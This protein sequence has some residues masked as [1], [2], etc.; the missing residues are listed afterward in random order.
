MRLTPLARLPLPLRSGLVALAALPLVACGKDDN[1]NGPSLLE[2]RHTMPEAPRALET[3][4]APGVLASPSGHPILA[5]DHHLYLADR[6]NRQVVR[7]DRATLGREVSTDVGGRPEQL[8]SNVDE[9]LFVSLRHGEILRMSPELVVEARVKVGVEAY[10]LALS[11]DG[12]TLYATLPH[13]GELVTFDAL[14]FEELDRASLGF[15][16]RGLAVSPKGWLVVSNEHGDAVRVDLDVQG[17]PLGG[18]EDIA[19]RRGNPNEH[20]RGFRLGAMRATRSLAATVNPESGAVY[21]A[22]I[23][24]APGDPMDLLSVTKSGADDASTSGY[25]GSSAQAPSFDAPLRPIEVT[26]TPTTPAGAVGDIEAGVPVKDVLTGEPL[27]DL[28]DQPSDILH[29]PT[30]S[31]LFMTGFGTD[32]VLVLSTSEGDPMRSPVG[33]IDVGR[34]PRGIAIAPDGQHAYVLNEHD[35]SVSRIDLA[36]FFAMEPA[37]V[38]T[39]DDMATTSFAAPMPDFANTETRFATPD[40]T[41]DSPRVRPVHLRATSSAT[42]ATDPL[43]PEVRRGARVFTYARNSNLSHAGQFACA[44]CHFEGTEDKLVWVISDGPRQT[45]SL[46]GRLTG[47]APFNW[48]GTKDAL[49]DNMAQTIT[50]MGGSGLDPDE[51][52]DLEQFLLHGLEAPPNPNLAPDGTL[53]ADQRAGK[54]IFESNKTG[55]A[56]CHQPERNFTDGLTHDVGTASETERVLHDMALAVDPEA[57]PPWVLDTPTLKGLFYTAP[58]F[59][60]GSAGDLWAV[61]EREG[62]RMGSTKHL[63]YDE[64]RQLIAYLLTL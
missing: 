45:P 52:A 12:E 1:V 2:F 36:P 31:L 54:A 44:S 23:T 26:V 3:S 40:P 7:L 28:I 55:C 13:A 33:V 35:L 27:I 8:A 14:T 18:L 59:H 61:L 10:G 50:R 42:Y 24:A 19:L 49:Q 34:A 15:T 9:R 57:R 20:V 11:P 47:T 48:A 17:L 16:P 38:P 25:G 32:N 22:H 51:L 6:D 64:K 60:D 43:P 53:T 29:H 58:Y 46:A 37:E 4:D 62:S 56:S 30:W 21:L 41:P 39:F 63:S 5:T